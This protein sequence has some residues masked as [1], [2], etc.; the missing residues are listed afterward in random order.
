LNL[1]AR[2]SFSEGGNPGICKSGIRIDKIFT[3][4]IFKPLVIP[5]QAGIQKDFKTFFIW[6]PRHGGMTKYL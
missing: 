6:I 2:R 1:P 3:E 4:K 5:A